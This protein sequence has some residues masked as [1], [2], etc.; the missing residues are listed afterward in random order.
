[1]IKEF[2]LAFLLVSFLGIDSTSSVDVGQ[3]YYLELE[4]NSKKHYTQYAT[5]GIIDDSLNFYQGFPPARGVSIN[6]QS[7]K[8]MILGGGEEI[9]VYKDIKKVQFN[10]KID[11]L[12]N[13]FY[14]LS[15]EDEVKLSVEEIDNIQFTRILSQGTPGEFFSDEL[16]NDTNDWYNRVEVN[17]LFEIYDGEMCTY[18]FYGNN[19]FFEDQELKGWQEDLK[20]IFENN[21]NV[22]NSRFGELTKEL[23][24]L[25]IFYSGI[26]SC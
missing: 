3:L 4:Y 2:I 14:S 9:I 1:M 15:V 24:D 21:L 6:D 11:Y 18:L 8:R 16:I 20:T 22:D 23:Y 25:R 5:Y 12:P 19:Q 26:C 13:E 7:V 17:F 10:N